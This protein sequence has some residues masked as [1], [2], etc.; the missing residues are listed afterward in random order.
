MSMP[1]NRPLPDPRRRHA[2][3]LAGRAAAGL[4]LAGT[5]GGASALPAVLALPRP[6]RLA[7]RTAGIDP[8]HCSFVLRDLRLGT[9][10][11]DWQ[12]DAPRSPASV[13]KLVT[14]YAALNL[15]GPDYRWR[16]PVYAIGPLQDGVLAGDLGF[17]GSG[18]PHL[19]AQDLWRLALRLR[20]LGLRR[21]AG[22]VVVDRSAFNLPPHDPAQFDGR[23]LA[24]YNVGPDAFLVGFGSV[25]MHMEAQGGAVRAWTEP[26]LHGFAPRLPRLEPGAC[27]SPDARL[28]PDFSQTLAPDLQ[29]S[30]SPECG[31]MDWN[32][33][34]LMPADDFVQAVL[35]AV[36]RDAGIEWTGTVVS[37]RIPPGAHLLS[38][39]ESEPLAVLVRDIDKY[40]NNVMAQ[41]VFLTLALH[42]GLAPA[43]FGRA[44]QVVQQWLGTQGLA[45]PDLVLDNGCG[46]S[47]VARISASDL[48]RLLGAAWRGPL[49]PEFVSSLPLSGED[50]TLR[51]R[52]G[53]RL[54]GMLHAKTGTLDGVLALAGYLQGDDG[55]RRSVVALVNDPRAELAWPAL[56]ALLE[57]G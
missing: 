35:G 14:M 32:L 16:T 40:S 42:A 49:M 41:Q 52:L 54:R 44:A 26:P 12:S 30:W 1:P 43:D 13:L 37:G 19:M 34:A 17:A 24:P 3:L 18:D 2:M 23:P 29:G 22:N 11:V 45:M 5:A 47:R 15:L 53:G 33:A 9:A 4:A 57:H 36:L 50:G 55:R 27:G 56:Q 8:A 39:W 20:G 21:I 38:T 7:L 28:H 25:Q 51:R 48:D 10:L 6:V 46:L 31:E